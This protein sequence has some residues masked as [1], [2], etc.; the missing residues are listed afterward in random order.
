MPP[1]TGISPVSSRSM[2][3][4]PDPL[5]PVTKVISPAWNSAER[6]P[7]AKID[8]PSASR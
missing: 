2:V 7:T 1:S 5:P 8:V 4:L 3:D 6:G